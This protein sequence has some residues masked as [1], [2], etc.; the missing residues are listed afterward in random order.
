MSPNPTDRAAPSR[1]RA[2][3]LAASALT[4]GP[5]LQAHPPGAVPLRRPEPRP[6]SAASGVV[7]A[8]GGAEDRHEGM[9]VL[10]HFVQACGGAGARLVV[11]TA[12]SGMPQ[13]VWER[14]AQA[15][16]RLGV[17]RLT[18]LPLASRAQADDTAAVREILGADGVFLTG[19]DQRRLLSVLG[20]SAVAQALHR[21]RAQRGLCVAGTS[22]GAAALSRHMLAEGRATALP[23]KG[24]ARL[25]AG[26]ALLPNAIVDQHFS[27]RQRLPRLMSAVAQRPELLG[28]GIDEDTALVV[29]PG[30]GVEVVG[31][32]AVTLLD[33]RH[34]LSSAP[35]ARPGDRLLLAGLQLHVLPAGQRFG[36]EADDGELPPAGLREALALLAGPA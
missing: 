19:G 28:V 7:M 17:Q 22:A 4:T 13:L 21:A 8:I 12:A 16:G 15:F 20:D 18:E 5:A 14:Y 6:A 30:R 24:A 27:Q 32:G 34:M 10:R 3:L 25:D 23:E 2:L 26:L 31:T 29:E 36:I 35:R 9:A 11:L 33:G 1:R